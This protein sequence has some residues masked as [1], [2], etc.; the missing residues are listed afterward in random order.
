M[1][2]LKK[3]KFPN[4]YAKF[5]Q[6][7]DLYVIA[8]HMK[9]VQNVPESWCERCD[10][11][12]CQR[13]LLKYFTVRWPRWRWAGKFEEELNLLF[14]PV[15]QLEHIFSVLCSPPTPFNQLQKKH[16]SSRQKRI[17]KLKSAKIGKR[18]NRKLSASSLLFS[19]IWKGRLPSSRQLKIWKTGKKQK[20]QLSCL[21]FLSSLSKQT[22]QL[23]LS[24]HFC[25]PS[26]TQTCI[27]CITQTYCVTE[28]CKYANYTQ[29]NLTLFLTFR[30]K[31]IYKWQKARKLEV[32]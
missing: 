7:L 13:I 6:N 9:C 14:V 21:P 17:W 16:L 26:K 20:R 19:S 2:R 18:W 31:D 8:G 28:T 32:D 1:C 30:H 25:I 15:L 5:G 22:N 4:K 12:S 10:G 23:F 11:R 3:N 24:V 29:P 27:H